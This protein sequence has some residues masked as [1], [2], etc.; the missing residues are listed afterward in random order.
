VSANTHYRLWLRPEHTTTCSKS[1]RLSQTSRFTGEVSWPPQVVPAA[2]HTA[3]CPKSPRV[4]QSSRFRGALG[5]G[6]NLQLNAK[7]PSRPSRQVHG[8]GPVSP[9][10]PS[11]LRHQS[12]TSSA[13]IG[14]WVSTP[15]RP[16]RRSTVK[17]V[18]FWWHRLP[19]CVCHRPSAQARCLCH[20]PELHLVVHLPLWSG[21]W[22]SPSNLRGLCVSVVQPLL[23]CANLK[24]VHHG[25]TENTEVSL[26]RGNRFVGFDPGSPLVPLHSER[27]TILVAQASSLCLPSA[28]RTGKMPVP[29]TGASPCCTLSS[30][31]RYL[32]FS[33]PSPWTLCLR[34]STPPILCE[35]VDAILA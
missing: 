33:V 6:R 8:R 11:S 20:R 19:A 24:R 26:R 13:G 4:S 25:D 1:P 16:W 35:S 12:G 9:T 30:V 32:V 2:R 31:E 7:M 5:S 34:G 27:C 14:S 29:P 18:Q 21:T 28:K 3:T 23:F 15:N 10:W 17:G 22:S